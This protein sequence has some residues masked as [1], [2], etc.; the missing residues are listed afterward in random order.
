MH[1][2]N[3][4]PRRA[5]PRTICSTAGAAETE[6]SRLAFRKAADDVCEPALEPCGIHSRE[7]EQADL[8][9]G[10]GVVKLCGAGEVAAKH[11]PHVLEVRVQAAFEFRESLKSKVKVA[12][13]QRP[14]RAHVWTAVLPSVQRRQEI[15]GRRQL[16]VD[17]ER[18]LELVQESQ[19]LIGVGSGRT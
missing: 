9:R 6:A 7:A 11:G 4:Q 10:E 17:V 18:L 12:N 14:P 2:A 3:R 8:H 15:Q 5:K 1:C 19:K 13:V 16:D